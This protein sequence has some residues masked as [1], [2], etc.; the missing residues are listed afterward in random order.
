MLIPNVFYRLTSAL[1]KSLRDVLLMSFGSSSFDSWVKL[2]VEPS[3]GSSL[4]HYSLVCNRRDQQY[5][6]G[7][8]EYCR[9]SWKTIVTYALHLPNHPSC[10]LSY[11]L[12][13]RLHDGLVEYATASPLAIHRSSLT[14]SRS[15][16]W[17]CGLWDQL[18]LSLMIIVNVS[19]ADEAVGGCDQMDDSFPKLMG[20]WNLELAECKQFSYRRRY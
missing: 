10:A 9:E 4:H 16:W 13:T 11:P 17:M 19:I 5:Q 1:H 2:L 6:G 8:I 7:G 14:T 20:D 3:Q 15:D 12:M 18:N